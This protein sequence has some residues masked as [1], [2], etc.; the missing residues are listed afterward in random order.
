MPYF[1]SPKVIYGKGALKRLSAELEGKGV[2]AVIITDR[3]LKEKC[4]ELVE[5]VRAAGY[6]VNIWDGVEADPTLDIALAASRFLLE[7][8]PQWVIG[9]GGGSAIDTAKAAWVLY[10]RPDL[11]AGDLTKAILPK[12]KLNL[13][14]KAR[15][16]AVPTTSGTGA[17]GTWVAVLT[18]RAMNRKIV[19]AHNDIVPDLSVLETSLTLAL[20]KDL[21]A[22]TGLDVIAHAVDGYIS[23]QQNDFSDG[24]CLQAVKMAM[25]WLPVAFCDGSNLVARE[26][27]QNAATIAGLGFGNSNTGLSH[28]LGHSAGA[29]FHLSH[30]RAIGI[31]LPY[32][33]TYI[34]SHPAVQGVPD[35][36]ER[37]AVL[38]RFVGINN[39]SPRHSVDAFVGRIRSIQK[40]IGEPLS[41][42]DAGITEDRMMREIETLVRIAEKDPNMYTTP[43]ECKGKALRDLFEL[44]WRG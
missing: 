12:V 3:T 22:S 28:A 44:M 23:R 13:R 35:P 27:M 11:A 26:K 19:F 17:D 5:S 15:F 38:A 10:E 4:T 21:T 8:N 32:S 41:L 16:V 14:Q 9:F 20:P 18:D 7:S 6:E 39:P 33:L 30:G 25:D 37:L 43:C 1:L 42:R 36:V 31:A 34:A 24:P 2:R 29:V 40:E